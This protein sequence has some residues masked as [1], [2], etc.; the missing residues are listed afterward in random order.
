[1]HKAQ[2][3]AERE[4]WRAQWLQLREPLCEYGRHYGVEYFSLEPSEYYPVVLSRFRAYLEVLSGLSAAAARNVLMADMRDTL[5][6]GNP[7]SPAA[8]P[9][10]R[11]SAHEPGTALPYVLFTE[12]GDSVYHSTIRSDPYDQAWVRLPGQLAASR[13]LQHRCSSSQVLSAGN[14]CNN[15]TREVLHVHPHV[16]CP[17]I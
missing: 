3:N 7:F 10:P 8:L 16:R 15:A 17:C 13:S 5:F 2:E 11:E 6:Q 4:A 14:N 1:M 12:E 9:L